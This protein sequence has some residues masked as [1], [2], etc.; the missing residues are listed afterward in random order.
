MINHHFLSVCQQFRVSFFLDNENF[1]DPSH[2][3]NTFRPLHY[4]SA[5]NQ[6][7]IFLFYKKG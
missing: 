3:E 1:I 4:D 6:F 2:S 5:H 7:H